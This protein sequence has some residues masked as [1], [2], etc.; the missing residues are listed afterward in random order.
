M[1]KKEKRRQHS[2]SGA[3]KSRRVDMISENKRTKED[4]LNSDDYPTRGLL[5]LVNN[6]TKWDEREV[7][8][9]F[10]KNSFWFEKP[11][12][13]FGNDCLAHAFNYAFKHPILVSREQVHRL[14][15]LR[16]R[17]GPDYTLQRVMNGGYSLKM[18]NNFVI[19]D[20]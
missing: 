13:D 14:A 12:N 15:L 20:G 19:K 18:F 10:L 4:M 2:K 8:P 11:A 9:E 16:D 7:L 3:G 5:Y 17:K 1:S 6:G